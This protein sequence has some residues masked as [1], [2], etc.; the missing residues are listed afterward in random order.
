MRPVVALLFA[1]D[2]EGLWARVVAG[3]VF[4]ERSPVGMF[5]EWFCAEVVLEPGRTARL[6]PDYEGR[7][8]D[9]CG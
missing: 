1:V 7:T 6:D 2:T 3:S 4:G 8:G 9:L 5:S